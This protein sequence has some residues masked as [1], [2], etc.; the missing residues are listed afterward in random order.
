MAGHDNEGLLR[1]PDG[2]VWGAATAAY[3]IEGAWNEDGKGPSTW[4]TF[5][6][7]PRKILDGS[8]GDV[9]CDHYHRYQEDVE[10]MAELGLPAYR[11]SISWPRILPQGRGAVN[12]AG[13][14]FY[15]RLVD[16]LL[17]KQIEPYL[18]LYH[19]DLPQ[20]LE[21]LG[22]WASRDT[23]QYFAEYARI[24]AERLGD[25]V[26]HWITHNEPVVVSLLGYFMGEYAPGE[27]NPTA[28][29]QA[30]HHLLLSHGWAAEAARAASPGTTEIGIVQHLRPVH[31]A[32]DTDEDRQAA[33]RYDGVVNR[34]FLDP[35]FLGRYP[36]DT[37][38]LLEIIMPEIEDG[39]MKAISTPIDFL[40]VNY[41]TRFVV[42]H[43]PSMMLIE[44]SEVQPPDSEYSQLWEIYKPGLYEMLTRLHSDYKPKRILI[45]ENGIPVPDGLDLDGRVRDYRRTAYL[46][47]N[48]AQL[49][50][51]MA[52][53]VPVEG[54]FVWSLLDNFEW[55]HGYQA[56]FGIVYLDYETQKRIIKES[57]RWYAQVIQQ[58][59]LDPTAVPVLVPSRL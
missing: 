31:P 26:T 2:F 14:D 21:D 46:R 24:V 7:K 43:D 39:D 3:Q 1:F 35:I 38:A 59:S 48:L 15:D 19:W 44:A 50:R 49:H 13:L 4:D 34:F 58:N 12:A 32:T 6:H 23:A 18:T 9:A 37:V 27:Q 56:R 17:A 5:C 51:A 57:G 41:Y 22:G 45:T 33:S 16:A 8:S 40:G 20:A 55:S 25:R 54:Y 42:R 36:E 10:V 47:D 29:F 52:G 30:A 53:G 28:A 11:F